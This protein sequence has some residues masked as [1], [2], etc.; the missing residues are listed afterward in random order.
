LID[1][2]GKSV[3]IEAGAA[4]ELV[5][6]TLRREA[7]PLFRYAASDLAEVVWAKTEED[8]LTRM[9]FRIRGRTDEMI[10]FRGVNFFPQSL[11]SVVAEF[12]LELSTNYR[13]VRPPAVPGDHLDVVMESSIVPERRAALAQAIEQRISAL[14]QV[15][16]RVRLAP[17]G[18]LPP[19][20]NKS[21]LIVDSIEELP[22][23]ESF[24]EVETA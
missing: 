1:A 8:G 4:G 7:Q 11:M 12:P 2:K 23:A 10:V 17:V 6:S 18:A 21:R 20:D 14:L 16:T 15:R 13:L 3:P 19:A 22:T 9:R 5:F 24:R